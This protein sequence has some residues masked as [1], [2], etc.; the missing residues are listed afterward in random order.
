[1]A[2]YLI[3]LVHT[4]DQ[5]PTS[6]SKVRERVL[7]GMPEMPQ[8]AAKLGVKFVIGP[9]VL[10]AEHE[11]FAVVEADKPEAVQDLIFQSGLIQ[12]NTIRVTPTQPLQDAMKELD[13]MPP[14]IY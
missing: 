12:W 6:N 10:A 13:K 9:L 2:Q 11:S 3:R 4:S 7:K 14:P 5:C 8:L 1:M